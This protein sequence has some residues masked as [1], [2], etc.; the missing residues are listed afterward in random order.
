[1]YGSHDI[2]AN[3]VN[4]TID[5]K[6]HH[7]HIFFNLQQIGTKHVISQNNCEEYTSFPNLFLNN[8]NFVAH[9]NYNMHNN[10]CMLIIK[11]NQ[12]L[13]SLVT[14]MK[15]SP[16]SSLLMPVLTKCMFTSSSSSSSL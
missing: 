10:N 8:N 15:L 9:P 11:R 2:F 13:Q 14:R 16:V 6:N 1:M 12:F 3:L 5:T 4:V 7:H